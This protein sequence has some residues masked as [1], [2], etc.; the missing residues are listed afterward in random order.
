MIMKQAIAAGWIAVL[1]LA[2]CG[3]RTV[4]PS[5]PPDRPTTPVRVKT[6]ESKTH[7]S[8][9]EIVGITRAE[10]R[11]TIE[12]RLSGYVAQM[13]VVPGQ[14]VQAG[15]LLARLNAPELQA[16]LDQALAMS[17]LAKQNCQRSVKLFQQDALTRQAFEAAR[18]RLRI[19]SAAVIEAETILDY[20]RLTAPFDC[21]VSRKLV[22]L[23]DLAVPGKPLIIIEDPATLRFEA[24][25]P[26]AHIAHTHPGAKLAVR[27]PT[28]QKEL[29]GTVSEIS[30]VVDT[31]TYTVRVALEL[32]VTDGLRVKLFGRVAVPLPERTAVRIPASAVRRHGQLETVFVVAERKAHLR[33]VKTGK[34]IDTEIELISGV[35]AGEQVVIASDAVLL[36]GQ[37]VY[38]QTGRRTQTALR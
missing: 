6:V 5:V 2:G 38:P 15:E 4:A 14:Q 16:R 10:T 22:N 34:H 20:T 29:I 18:T 17:R 12:A 25:V 11:S 3:L 28:L 1:I 9:L 27:L 24:D 26:A 31:L 35:A 33:Y 36:D 21:V 7:R 23:G 37:E 32:P 30:P 13:L 8:T 19:A